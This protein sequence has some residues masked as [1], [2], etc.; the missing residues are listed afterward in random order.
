MTYRFAVFFKTAAMSAFSTCS[1]IH[2]RRMNSEAAVTYSY[3]PGRPGKDP[4]GPNPPCGGGSVGRARRGRH[5]RQARQQTWWRRGSGEAAAR[6]NVVMVMVVV[7]VKL[8]GRKGGK[9]KGIQ[10][11][12]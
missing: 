9:I 4:H 12:L 7:V 6:R 8:E 3:R 1:Y 2:Q 11:I 10:V 5:Q